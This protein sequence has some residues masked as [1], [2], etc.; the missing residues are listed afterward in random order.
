MCIGGEPLMGFK[1]VL[2]YPFYNAELGQLF[3][4]RTLCMIIALVSHILVS[5]MARIVFHRKWLSSR[6]DVLDCFREKDVQ[7]DTTAGEEK[8]IKPAYSLKN[9]DG[10]PLDIKDFKMEPIPRPKLKSVSHQR[11]N[12][13]DSYAYG[14]DNSGFS[15][16]VE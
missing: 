11:N 14:V 9:I 4:F 15:R 8:V 6:W 10:L 16:D 7:S 12:T 2:A 1:P 3:P 5:E 13:S